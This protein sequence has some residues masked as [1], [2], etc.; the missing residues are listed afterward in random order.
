MNRSYQKI[1]RIATLYIVLQLLCFVG[2]FLLEGYMIYLYL[3]KAVSFFLLLTIHLLIIT[4]LYFL[5]KWF[6]RPIID[7]RVTTVSLLFTALMG[8][9][10]AA[11]AVV[12][13]ILYLVLKGPLS[14]NDKELLKHLLP[15][16][17][18][19]MSK[20]IY[21]RL[22]YGLDKFD[23]DKLP[24][25]FNDVLVYGSERQK[26]IVIERMLRYFRVEFSPV[27]QE[28]LNDENNSIRVLAATAVTRIDKQY[29][30]E[31]IELNH[32]IQRKPNDFSVHLRLARQSEE[33]S[34]LGFIDEQRRMKYSQ[35]AI[36]HYQQAIAIDPKNAPARVS[37][38]EN[39]YLHEKYQDII[40][41]LEIVI[42]S[43]S[44]LQD[45]AIKWYLS[46]MFKLNKY[47]EIREFTRTKTLVLKED[48]FEY[49]LLL[50]IIIIWKRGYDTENS[51]LNN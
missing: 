51:P 28:A 45:Q 4:S 15:E 29:S 26:R 41:C 35:M 2:V 3:T 22:I 43:E 12:G 39:Y 10:G 5:L 33:Y 37:L 31:N 42:E 11:V 13:M 20:E 27:L 36:D 25:I 49:D 14:N 9:L 16:E 38:A 40:D 34:K 19:S 46:A 21:D 47:A 7:K 8:P 17:N 50:Y 23:A 6:S 18:E 24:T 1:N 44:T 32:L 48:S 30:E